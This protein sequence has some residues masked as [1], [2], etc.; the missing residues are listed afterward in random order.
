MKEIYCQGK[1]F[2]EAGKVLIE[3]EDNNFFVPG[4]INICLSAEIFLK[5]INASM[6]N[7]EDEIEV[8]GTTVYQGRDETLKILP[9]GKGHALSKLFDGLPEDIRN[10]ITQYARQEKYEGSVSEGLKKY[11]D[12]FVEWRYIYEKNDPKSLGTHPLF[13]IVN[14]VIRYC[15]DNLNKV[16]DCSANEV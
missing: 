1:A 7:L 16:I 9:S 4:M 13:K 6:T 11:D 14:A 15:E 2:G 12:V 10:E 8:N 5:S 3:S